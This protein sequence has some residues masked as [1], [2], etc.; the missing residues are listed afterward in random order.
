MEAL[1][2]EMYQ[3]KV[4]RTKIKASRN[5]N[6]RFENKILFVRICPKNYFTSKIHCLNSGL[7][8]IKV[9]DAL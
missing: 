4:F 9:F 6:I 3:S 1:P 8:S 7:K 2:K 5:I